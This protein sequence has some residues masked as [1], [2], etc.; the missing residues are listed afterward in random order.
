LAGGALAAAVACADTT[1]VSVDDLEGTWNATAF[2]FTDQ[3]NTSQQVDLISL[4]ATYTLTIESPN[5]VSSVFIFEGNTD[6][7]SNN[8][9]ISRDTLVANGDTFIV[10]LTG[11]VLLLTNLGEAFDFDDDGSDDPATLRIELVRQ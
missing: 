6:S 5:A 11:D 4:G 1:G 9:T 8:F 7:N 3:T 2:E 10:D